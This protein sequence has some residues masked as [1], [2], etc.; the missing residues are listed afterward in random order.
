MKKE[1][2]T[3]NDI[4]NAMV[5]IGWNLEDNSVETFKTYY[6]IAKESLEQEHEM[7][8]DGNIGFILDFLSIVEEKLKW[9]NQFIKGEKN[10]KEIIKVW[11]NY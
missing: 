2:L 1:K 6:D 4:F 8:G 11:W 9:V 5:E 7:G 3:M 10:E